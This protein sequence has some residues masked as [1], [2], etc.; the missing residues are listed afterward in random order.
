MYKNNPNNHQALQKKLTQLKARKAELAKR[1]A[2]LQDS[3]KKVSYVLKK[4]ELSVLAV[5]KA[6]C[7]KESLEMSLRSILSD[8]HAQLPPLDGIAV[9][10]ITSNISV[11][12]NQVFP[13]D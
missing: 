11:I 6:R 10:A 13:I 12:L 5:E 9:N 2:Y 8:C 7:E 3:V 4:H 1:C